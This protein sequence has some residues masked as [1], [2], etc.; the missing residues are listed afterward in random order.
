MYADDT[1]LCYQSSDITQLNE[2]INSDLKQLDTW[3]QGNELSLNVTKTHSMLVSTKQRHNILQSQNKDLDL[4]IRE[5]GLQVV[6]KTKYLGVEID[7]S[8]D[9]KEQIR[10]VSTSV[11]RAVGFLKHAKSFLPKDTLKSFYTGIVEPHF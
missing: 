9:W 5:N 6:Q 1:S 7:C 4:E 11:S 8:L 3:L 2:A 10:A